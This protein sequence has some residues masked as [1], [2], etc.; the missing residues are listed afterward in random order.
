MRK[1]WQLEEVNL[2]L[3]SLMFKSRRRSAGTFK[4]PSLLP[5]P[6]RT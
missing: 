6:L 4:S 5:D 2:S 1:G 3:S